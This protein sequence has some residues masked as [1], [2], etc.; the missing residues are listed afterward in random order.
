MAEPKVIK[1]GPGGGARRGMPRPKIENPC[2]LFG[3]LMG[4]V[5]KYYPIHMLTI[6]VCILLT[7]FSSVQGTLFTR[8]LID[9]YIQ[10]MI[11]AENPDYGPLLGAMARVAVFYALGVLAAF[12]QAKVMIYINQ[13]T[14]RRLREEL[15]YTW[16]LFLSNT[17]T[18][19]PTAISCRSTP[20]ISIL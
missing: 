16:N 2:K 20:M 11:G 14:L 18:L 8:T 12:V 4:Y 9:S 15:L 1:G 13:G 19:I 6:V 17:L 7:V 5:F 3:R 10:P